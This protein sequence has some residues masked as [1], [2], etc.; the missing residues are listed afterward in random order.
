M[1]VTCFVWWKKWLSH[2]T[3]LGLTAK[4]P[5]FPIFSPSHQWNHSLPRLPLGLHCSLVLHT[6]IHESLLFFGTCGFS[7]GT[8]LAFIVH[9]KLIHSGFNHMLSISQ[10]LP[11]SLHLPISVFPFPPAHHILNITRRGASGS[12]CCACPFLPWPGSTVYWTAPG[13]NL[14]ASF[15]LSPC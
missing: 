13:R 6:S 8:F 2:L 14:G 1:E 5:S 7:Q 3:H 4:L 10:S 9:G 12:T 15:W 11:P